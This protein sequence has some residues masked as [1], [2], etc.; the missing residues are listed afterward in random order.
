MDKRSTVYMKHTDEQ[1]LKNC[2][3]KNIQLG[4][5]F[6]DYLSSIDRSVKTIVNYKNDLDIFW[7]WNLDYN[8]NKFFIDLTK[9]EI[10]K[11]QNHALNTWGWSSSRIRRV[12]STL[13]SLS[14]YIENIL[15]DEFPNYKSIIHKIEN[16]IKETVREKTILTKEQVEYLLNELISQKKYQ[17][18]CAVALAIYSGSRKSELT[19]FKVSYFDENNIL[20]DAMYRTPEKIKTKGRGAKLGKPLH[21]YVLLE[22]NKYLKP[23][24][25]ERTRLGID[26]EWLLVSKENNEWTQMK[27]STLDSYAATCSK[28][29]QVPFYFHCARHYLTTLLASKYH[30]PAKIIQEFF[31]WESSDMISIYDDSEAIDDFD[32]YFSKEGIK[33]IDVNN[34]NI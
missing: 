5:D 22:F 1:K 2:N 27:I 25:Q 21:K 17:T 26:S 20:Y 14:N 13:S 19:R 9:R 8:D 11:F 31:G 24:L 33:K 34:F 23:W 4:S 28:I 12:K 7:C 6:L 10:I 15:D 3:I 29:L 16:P 18:A 30:L 32:K